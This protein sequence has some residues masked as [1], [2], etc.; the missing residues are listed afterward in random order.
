MTNQLINKKIDIGI[1]TIKFTYEPKG[2]WKKCFNL[3]NMMEIEYS[4]DISTVPKSIAIIPWLCN[5]LPVSWIMDGTIYVDEVD[6]DFYNSIYNFKQGFINIYPMFEFKGKLIPKKIIDN[7][8]SPSGNVGLLFSGGIDSLYSLITKLE[9]SPTLITL[10]GADILNSKT[11]GIVN[12]RKL[13]LDARSTFNVDGVFIKTNFRTMFNERYLDVKILACAKD[14]WYGFQHGI[15]IIGHCAPFT[16]IKK[17][18]TLFRSS[19][20]PVNDM[21]GLMCASLTGIDD[22]VMIA[23]TRVKFI[24]DMTRRQEKVFRIINYLRENGISLDINVCWESGLGKNCCICGKCIRTIMSIV[25]AGGEPR[26]FGFNNVDY[27]DIKRRF[28][29]DI[30]I[31]KYEIKIWFQR[32][33][34]YL[35]NKDINDL[36]GILDWFGKMDF[37]KINMKPKKQI[38]L[39]IK[40]MKKIAKRVIYRL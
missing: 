34:Y 13:V 23:N 17:S 37:N 21:K 19:S 22:K 20:F 3:D 10:L 25:S 32:Q 16:Y 24:G 1:Y 8:F 14:W 2:I 38:K 33:N 30:V 29:N 28:I 35:Q 27:D 11:E 15:G 40:S 18:S 7:E 9:S 5:M 4:F 36:D 6:R 39:F 31:D 12:L 26:D